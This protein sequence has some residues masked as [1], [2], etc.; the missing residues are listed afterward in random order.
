MVETIAAISTSTMS[1]GGISI[2]R[3]SGTDA[4]EIVD[5]IFKA[6]NNKKLIEAKSHTVHYGNIYNGEELI[7]EVLA[8]VMKAPNTYTRE[9]IV[10]I[11]CH[12]GVLV[13]R[14]VLEA[15]IGAGA[16]PAEPGEFTKRAFL[17]G[18]ID[19]SQAEAVI[20]VINSRNEYALKSSVAQLDGKLSS[21]IR[22]IRD[23]ILNHVAYVEAAL[24]D[25]EHFELDNYVNNIEND[26]DNCVD[27]VDNLLKT[28]DNGR[29]MHDGIRTV[30]LGK[31]NAGKS[32]LM[33]ALAKEERAIVTDIEG[34]TRD[35]LEEQ[36][37]L[38]GLLL[39]LIDTA[40][41]RKTDDYVESIGVD[42]AKKYAKDAD[43]IIFVADCTRPLDHNDEE[44]IELIR[45][46]KVIVL[47]N[48]SDMKAV[49]EPED[50]K[51]KINCSVVNISAKNHTGLDELEK[52]VKNM[53]FD[54]QISFN[55]E[56]YITNIRHKNLLKEALDSL[57][58]VKDG[59]LS[60]V[61]EDFLTIDMM[62]AYEK[63]GLIIGEEVEDDSADQIFSKFCMGK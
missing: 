19:L 3:V 31:T 14:K 7:D 36:I 50:I 12:G 17:N 22:E 38:G 23:I 61:S 9:N 27:I 21:K 63:L 34:T 42:K 46:K 6:K 33:N 16:R 2:V 59:I 25:P 43:L 10:E 35:V 28:A 47:L 45:D 58:L 53:F 55:E 56:I 41:I 30:I 48:K 49:L 52:T 32:S 15:V 51:E 24:D 20:D 5:K 13:T 8:I 11:D 4:V 26:V 37:N 62:N 54:G 40:G 29:I 60:G 18:R 57:Y 1:N 44:I 39:N